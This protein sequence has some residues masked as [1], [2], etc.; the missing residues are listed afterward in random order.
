[1]IQKNPLLMLQNMLQKMQRNAINPH[2][3]CHRLQFF[4][5]YQLVKNNST[6][7]I[8]HADTP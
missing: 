5:L 3:T 8:L 4:H 2:A 1:M 6:D 7:G